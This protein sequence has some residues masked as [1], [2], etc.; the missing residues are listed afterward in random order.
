MLIRKWIGRFCMHACIKGNKLHLCFDSLQNETKTSLSHVAT[1]DIGSVSKYSA[2]TKTK[3]S[4][5]LRLRLSA[6]VAFR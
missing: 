5:T 1:E 4:F 6:N 2:K 3:E